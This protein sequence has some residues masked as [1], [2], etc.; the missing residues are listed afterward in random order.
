MCLVMPS[1]TGN[2]RIGFTSAE[3]LL[4]I[5]LNVAATPELA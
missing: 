1:C 5:K 2:K 3:N 4:K